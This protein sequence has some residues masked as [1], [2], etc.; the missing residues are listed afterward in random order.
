[1]KI[2]EVPSKAKKK[3]LHKIYEMPQIALNKLK[4]SKIFKCIQNM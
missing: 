1:M 2:T 4:S 3:K